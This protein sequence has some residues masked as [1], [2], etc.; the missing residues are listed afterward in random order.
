MAKN[1]FWGEWEYHPT[2]FEDKKL[3]IRLLF[4]HVDTS[5]W[6]IFA[7]EWRESEPKP[8]GPIYRSRDELLADL[9]NIAGNWGF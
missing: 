1:K 8:T 3:G 2:R 6:R 5:H 9:P 7:H 4:A